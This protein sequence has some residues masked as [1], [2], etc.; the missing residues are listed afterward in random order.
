MENQRVYLSK[1]LLEN[2]LISLLKQKSLYKIS[3]RELCEVASINRSTFYKYFSSQFDLLN[4][5]E[6]NLLKGIDNILGEPLKGNETLEKSLIKVLKYLK[7]N[8]EFSKLLLNNNFDNEFPQK[9]FSLKGINEA[10]K[11]I[12]EAIKQT[13]PTNSS[14]QVTNLIKSFVV[15]GCFAVIR[16]WLDDDCSVKES[17]IAKLLTSIKVNN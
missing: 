11:G 5:M 14:E 8:K 2:A 6:N 10:I 15:T 17:V 9:L 13:L 7:E 4:Y 3:I 1:K 12:N 16:S